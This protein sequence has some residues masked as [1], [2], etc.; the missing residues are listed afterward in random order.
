MTVKSRESDVSK[1]KR[2]N[3]SNTKNDSSVLNSTA[4]DCIKGFFGIL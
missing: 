2:E 3:G 1:V 4:K